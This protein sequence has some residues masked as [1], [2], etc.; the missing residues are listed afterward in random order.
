MENAPLDFSSLFVRIGFHIE[1]IV[2]INK[3]GGA[4]KEVG[5]GPAWRA[6]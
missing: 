3:S 1:V 4:P 6:V 5:A 2:R